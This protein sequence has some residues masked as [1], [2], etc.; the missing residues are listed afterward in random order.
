MKAGFC[1][2]KNAREARVIL[3]FFFTCACLASL[4][5]QA[6]SSRDTMGRLERLENEIQTLNRAVYKGDRPPAGALP[7]GDAQI[8][9][10]TEARLQQLEND[11]R[12]LRGKIEEQAFEN[13]TL[14]ADLEKS[15]SD[16]EL[17]MSDLE[18]GGAHASGAPAVSGAEAQAF[19]AAEGETPMESAPADQYGADAGM[20]QPTP[21]ES[22]E[23]GGMKTT[24]G[25]LGVLSPAVPG[26]S[27]SASTGDQ[28]AAAYEDAFA[29]LKSGQYE[30]AG[31]GF[32]SFLAGHPDH[33]LAGNAQYWLGETHYVRGD[34]EAAARIFAEG[35]QRYPKGAKAPDNLLK[36]GLSLSG[37]RND[38]DA[39]VALA[40]IAKD[41]PAGPAPVLR[42]AEQEMTR[43]GCS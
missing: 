32:E 20:P 37:L 43:L 13:K 21:A 25:S 39:C 28:A 5:A 34:Y 14:R 16:L 7:P 27:A 23:A 6:Q 41:F 29:Q 18:R 36:L 22:P 17:R 35:Y 9:A 11:L 19:S 31:K 33:V 40:Q 1:F 30:S 2:F 24:G 42:R 12:D 38:A 26:G 10:G 8:Q 3:G 15:R 4:P